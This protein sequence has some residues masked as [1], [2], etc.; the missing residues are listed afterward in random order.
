VNPEEAEHTPRQRLDTMGITSE[1]AERFTQIWTRDARL[2]FDQPHHVE[3]LLESLDV[4][5]LA[6]PP[7]GHTRILF[8][9]GFGP[10]LRGEAWNEGLEDWKNGIGAFRQGTGT[11]TLFVRTQTTAQNARA[12][13]K[14]RKDGTYPRTEMEH[15]VGFQLATWPDQRLIIS[16]DVGGRR[17]LEV[18][19]RTYTTHST[20]YVWD[21]KTN[22]LTAD[23]SDR[24]R[25]MC[26]LTGK[27]QGGPAYTAA[28]TSGD[29]K[30]SSKSAVSRF[31]GELHDMHPETFRKELV[32]YHYNADTGLWKLGEVA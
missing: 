5:G 12:L 30:P 20:G 6:S 10:T 19:G 31:L 29:L 24:I 25:A 28:V 1:E 3:R 27:W 18:R 14:K 17:I 13:L 16:R 32:D 26:L 11:S 23:V 22:L 8:V 21:P 4:A 7:P 9:D 15:A 2:Y